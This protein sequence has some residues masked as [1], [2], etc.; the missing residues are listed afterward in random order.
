MLPLS[1]FQNPVFIVPKTE[2]LVTWQNLSICSYEHIFIS[3][4]YGVKHRHI[5]PRR[6]RETGAHRFYPKNRSPPDAPGHRSLA[7]TAPRTICFTDLRNAR[8]RAVPD[9]PPPAKHAAQRHPL[10]QTE[11]PQ[12]PLFAERARR[13]PDYRMPGKLPMQYVKLEIK[14]LLAFR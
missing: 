11:G 3:L 13:F 14:K 9:F 8:K 10:L 1:P 12:H 2:F 5:Q 6:S 7:G 4:N